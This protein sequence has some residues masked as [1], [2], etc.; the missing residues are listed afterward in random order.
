MAS[1]A[2]PC[3]FWG[4]GFESRIHNNKHFSDVLRDNVELGN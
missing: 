4:R 1:S 2:A 3:F